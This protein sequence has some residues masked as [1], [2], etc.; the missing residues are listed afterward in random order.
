[1]SRFL[2]VLRLRSAERGRDS[3]EKAQQMRAG[4]GVARRNHLPRGVNDSALCRAL[5][6]VASRLCRAWEVSNCFLSLQLSLYLVGRTD[7]E[8][9]Y[10][11]IFLNVL[12]LTSS[13]RPNA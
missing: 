8:F 7:I 10:S 6:H 5:L 2:K 11:K 13:I 1:M 12:I 3:H 9:K 4:T